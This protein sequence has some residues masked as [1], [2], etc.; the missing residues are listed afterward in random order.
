MRLKALSRVLFQSHLGLILTYI[1]IRLLKVKF[2]FQSHL[3]LILTLSPKSLKTA[4]SQDFNPIL[5]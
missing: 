4:I 3:G 5:V 2:D 1:I